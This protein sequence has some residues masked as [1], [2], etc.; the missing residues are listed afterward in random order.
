MLNK[1]VLRWFIKICNT[2]NNIFQFIFAFLSLYIY[3]IRLIINILLFINCC[4][5]IKNRIDF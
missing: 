5:Y 4:N 3:E 1:I 2:D